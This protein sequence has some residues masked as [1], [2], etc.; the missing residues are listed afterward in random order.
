LVYLFGLIA[1]AVI[2]K[3]S[4]AL[5]EYLIKLVVIATSKTITKIK[6]FL[7][8]KGAKLRYKFFLSNKEYEK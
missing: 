4:N 7:P 8:K 2:V 1:I 5:S 6:K 3:R